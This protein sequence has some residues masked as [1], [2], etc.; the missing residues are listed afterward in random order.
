MTVT[1]AVTRSGWRREIRSFATSAQVLAHRTPRSYPSNAE[2]RFLPSSRSTTLRSRTAADA[3]GRDGSARRSGFRPNGCAHHPRP[4]TSAANFATPVKDRPWLRGVA[5]GECGLGTRAG[6]KVAGSAGSPS[7]TSRPAS[8]LLMPV[9]RRCRAKA[10]HARCQE[11][12]DFA[13]WAH[14]R[15]CHERGFRRR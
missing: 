6:V 14:L 15:C 2:R 9:C 7:V 10:G 3:L 4:Q 1:R 13:R 12:D 8:R 11:R 5:P